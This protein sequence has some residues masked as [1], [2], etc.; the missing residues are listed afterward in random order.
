MMGWAGVLLLTVVSSA[1]DRIVPDLPVLEARPADDV[2]EVTAHI[3]HIEARASR[4]LIVPV[5]RS[6]FSVAAGP[7]DAWEHRIDATDRVR[8]VALGPSIVA[9]STIESG[10]VRLLD[11]DDGHERASIDL[12]E[13]IG[14]LAVTDRF[15][16]AVRTSTAELVVMDLDG[17]VVIKVPVAG[18]PT[19]VATSGERAV[20]TGARSSVVDVIDL[21]D[22]ADLSDQADVSGVAHTT[23]EVGDGLR[24]AGIDGT[25]A[26]VTRPEA[27][28]VVAIDLDTG[29]VIDRL[30]VP[31][32]AQGLSHF[33]PDIAVG[34][35]H[36]AVPLRQ[37]PGSYGIASIER[38][39]LDGEHR[40]WLGTK[41]LPTELFVVDDYVYTGFVN[42]DGVFGWDL[43]TT[44]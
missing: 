41:G 26:Y 38:A 19:N 42:T 17:R 36:I 5:A 34:P 37:E 23:I 16:L 22:L 20:V 25:T 12:G 40:W 1:T 11:A 39:R 10:V 13:L 27:N 15:V 21:S 7:E 29:S 43:A 30:R 18:V 2:L 24:G 35:Q 3:D 4:I 33:V 31:D 44:D 6:Q 28:Q 32:L 14:S 9:L 8:D